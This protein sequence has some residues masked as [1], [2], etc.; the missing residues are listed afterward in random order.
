M[1]N[2]AFQNLTP[3]TCADH[4]RDEADELVVACDDLREYDASAQVRA[5]DPSG[6]EECKHEVL[7]EAC[8]TMCVAMHTALRAGFSVADVAREL[9]RK[10]EV[11]Q[12]RNWGSDGRHLEGGSE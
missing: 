5:L 1:A 2:P 3:S 7:E 6:Y 4:A 8:D 9:T 10:L 11:N 12:V